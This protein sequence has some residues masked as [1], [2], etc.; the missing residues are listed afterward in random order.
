MTHRIHPQTGGIIVVALTALAL[1]STAVPAS[2]RTPDLSPAHF[3]LDSHH[4][5]M[6]DRFVA[7]AQRHARRSGRQF[8]GVVLEIDPNRPVSVQAAGLE[9]LVLGLEPVH[10]W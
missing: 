2:A 5:A 8:A 7:S 6:L 1:S 10:H 4:L 3:M 9:P